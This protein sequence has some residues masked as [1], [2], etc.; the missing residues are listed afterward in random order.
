MNDESSSEQ[1]SRATIALQAQELERLRRQLAN[2]QFADE[3]RAALV[4]ATT[5]GTIASPV[6]HSRLLEMIV[7]TAAHVIRARAASLFL[8]EEESQ[9]LIFEVALGEKAEEVKKFRVPLGRGIAGL[10]AVSGQPIAIA[11]AQRDPRLA[12]DIGQSIGYL[13]Q[14]MLCVPLIY[15]DQTIGVLELLDKEGGTPFT[16]ADMEA[17]G[18]FANQ[19][20]VAIEQSRTHRGLIAMMGEVLKSLGTL[21]SVQLHDFRQR[22]RVFV[23]QFEDDPFFRQ[24]T[25]L[26]QLVQEI[27][28]QGE[29]EATLCRTI[30]TGV[31]EYLRSRPA[32]IDQFGATW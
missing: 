27:A 31:A 29:H 25:E 30:L 23:E 6:A 12:A 20:A 13:P 1:N 22:G 3:L 18:Y 10:V 11:D 19:A 5:A 9:E 28:W 2:H 7:E 32:Q 24:A 4:L 14:T 16:A 15:N 26:A 17:L 8:I 21:S